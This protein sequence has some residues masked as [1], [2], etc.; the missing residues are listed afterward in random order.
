[1]A[2]ATMDYRE[3]GSMSLGSADR[4]RAIREYKRL[5]ASARHALLLSEHDRCGL[6]T[7]FRLQDEAG[8]MFAQA[9]EIG[10]H[11]NLT[12]KYREEI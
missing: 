10:R 4:A 6:D 9:E 5:R 12:N 7:M 11:W 1:M 8:E 3:V 2:T